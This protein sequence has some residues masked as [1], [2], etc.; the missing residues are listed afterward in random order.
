MIFNTILF[1]WRMSPSPW[2]TRF[3]NISAA[4]IGARISCPK[5]ESAAMPKTSF[6]CNLTY[7]SE[8]QRDAP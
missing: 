8:A 3:T 1:D 7:F 5:I 2:I 6:V 4:A